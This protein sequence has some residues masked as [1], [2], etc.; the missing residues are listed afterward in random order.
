MRYH[1]QKP[2]FS[3]TVLNV[4]FLQLPSVFSPVQMLKEEGQHFRFADACG[5]FFQR[6]YRYLQNPVYER[7]FSS[8]PYGKQERKCTNNDMPSLHSTAK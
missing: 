5:E 7:E 1:I 2:S 8:L 6:I 3:P 4:S